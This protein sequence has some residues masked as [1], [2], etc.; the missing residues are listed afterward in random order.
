MKRK[1]NLIINII[2][3]FVFLFSAFSGLILWKIFPSGSG[4][5]GGRGITED[6]IFLGLF[7]R[8]WS[9]IHIYTSLIFAALVIIHLILHWS[10]IKNIPKIIRQKNG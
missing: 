9:D 5:R 2:S 10:W 3:F 6:N 8:E 7:R 1:L 4:F